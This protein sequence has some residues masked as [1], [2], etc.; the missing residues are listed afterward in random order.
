MPAHGA[1]QAFGCSQVDVGTDQVNE[2]EG[3]DPI[4]RRLHRRVNLSRR[5]TLFQQRQR[6][7][8]EGTGAAVHNETGAVGGVDH[9]LARR[10]GPVPG[11]GQCIGRGA[12]MGNQF[13]QFHHLRG[14]EEM[15]AQ[16]AF[17]PSRPCR[18]RG[19]GQR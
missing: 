8:I 10:A 3:T 17:G 6:L 4:A 12:G 9:H 11:T 18:N 19:D 14:V 7:A 2:P 15:Q 16:N 13:H 1:R 5:T